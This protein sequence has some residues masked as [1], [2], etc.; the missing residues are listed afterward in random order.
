MKTMTRRA[1]FH[2][3]A[4]GDEKSVVVRFVSVSI[5]SKEM[6]LQSKDDI[7]RLEED[8]QMGL[9]RARDFVTDKLE[10][11]LKTHVIPGRV[12]LPERVMIRWEKGASQMDMEVEQ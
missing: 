11:A 4:G 9:V 2:I 6:P 3:E 7:L 1:R 5:G 10:E 12:P 8:D